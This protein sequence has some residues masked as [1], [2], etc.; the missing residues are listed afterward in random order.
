MDEVMYITACPD[1]KFKRPHVADLPAL[2]SAYINANYF[3]SQGRGTNTQTTTI[4]QKQ[5]RESRG[6]GLSRALGS[7]KTTSRALPDQMEELHV[8]RSWW[9]PGQERFPLQAGSSSRH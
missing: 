5:G 6:E 1:K 7:E 2:A 8:E 3:P 9:W 4:E